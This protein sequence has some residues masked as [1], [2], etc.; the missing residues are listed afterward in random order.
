VASVANIVISVCRCS[1]TVE[2]KSWVYKA[3]GLF[4]RLLFL[5]EVMS[6]AHVNISNIGCKAMVLIFYH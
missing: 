1:L 2:R 4:Q 6:S 3:H 5:P